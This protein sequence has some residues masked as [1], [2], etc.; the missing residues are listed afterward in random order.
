MPSDQDN[1]KKAHEQYLAE[2]FIEARSDAIGST[3]H[4]LHGDENPDFVCSDDKGARIGLEVAQVTRGPI[5]SFW[6]RILN[7]EIELDPFDAGAMIYS[8][9]E[10][11]E[12]ARQERYSKKVDRCILML[13]LVNAPLDRLFVALEGLEDDFSSHGFEEVWLVDYSGLDAYRN[14]ELFGLHPAANW[15]H[16]ERPN[17]HTKPYG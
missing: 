17:A 13:A 8:L 3:L 2:Y 16:H 1:A 7:G 11:K 10:R 9:I 14:V 6:A 15:G 5:D 4:I 12:L